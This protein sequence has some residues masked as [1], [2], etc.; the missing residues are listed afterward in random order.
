MYRNIVNKS[1]IGEISVNSSLIDGV[2]A[3]A[4]DADENPSR[5]GL[6]IIVMC[7]TRG[8]SGA[9]YFS[10]DDFTVTNIVWAIVEKSSCGI[11]IYIDDECKPTAS[12]INLFSDFTLD[13][14]APTSTIAHL[15]N[16]CVKGGSLSNL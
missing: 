9:N 3:V 15:Q 6:D 7:S 5:W 11:R 14:F 2:V 8:Y 4:V 12:S 16:M 10:C 1:E 13:Y